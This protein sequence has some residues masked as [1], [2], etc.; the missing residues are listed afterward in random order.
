MKSQRVMVRSGLL[1]INKPAGW[2]SRD[3]VNRVQNVIGIRRC[4][5]AGTLDPLAT[6]VLVVC[7]GQATRLVSYVQQSPKRYLAEFRFGVTS[8]TDDIEGELATIP[9][10]RFPSESELKA[11]MLSYVGTIE[12]VPPKYSAVMVKGQRA[13]ALAR[14][15]QEFELKSKPVRIDRFDLAK[16]DMPDWQAE[17]VC[18][19][20]TYIRS[21]GRDL[22]AHFA[23]GA[24]MTSLVRESVGIFAIQKSISIEDLTPENFEEHVSPPAEAIRHLPFRLSTESETDFI[25]HGR[26]LSYFNEGLADQ[27]EVAILEAGGNSLIAIAEY[28][29]DEEIL[30][31]RIVF[32]HDV[33]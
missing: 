19:S 14:K 29:K 30:K 3:V 24:V 25:R 33:D 23:C 31:P 2:T 10:A 9:N 26:P 4:G 15:G 11:A 22:G 28:R 16:Y 1:N 32:P 20:G 27:A 7:F 12:Q 18:G 6:G 8:Q 21:L 17:I 13:Y 5:H